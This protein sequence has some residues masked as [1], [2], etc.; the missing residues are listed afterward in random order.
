MN[1]AEKTLRVILKIDPTEQNE[2][3]EIFAR[4]YTEQ[5]RQIEQVAYQDEKFEQ[6]IGISGSGHQLVQ[7]TEASLFFTR[8]KRVWVRTNGTE[9]QLRFRLTEIENRLNPQQFVRISQ[10]EIVNLK[11]VQSL[12]LSIAGTISLKLKDGTTCYVSRRSL[13]NF[14]RQLG[15]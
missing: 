12:D 4:E 9:L 15:L 14:K 7:T 8:N 5:I 2:R 6:F 13:P 11:H 10:S 1:K 3:V